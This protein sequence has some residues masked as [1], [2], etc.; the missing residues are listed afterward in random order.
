MQ[1]PQIEGSFVALITPFNRDGSIDFGAFR[2][3]V[4]FQREHGTAAILFMGSAGEA[5]PGTHICGVTANERRTLECS[6][7]RLV[8]C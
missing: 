2:E 6:H 8:S 1:K 3:L 7:Q 5:P 4:E